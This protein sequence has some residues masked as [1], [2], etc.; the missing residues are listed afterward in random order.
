MHFK[1]FFTVLV[2]LFSIS[3]KCQQIKKG[4]LIK[5]IPLTNRTSIGFKKFSKKQ[6]L[7]YNPVIIK[8]GNY[9]RVKGFDEENGSD[10]FIKI[11][12]DKN[13]LVL[14]Y[15]IKGYVEDGNNKVLHENALCV[16]V[17]IEKYKVVETLQSACGGEW[18]EHNQWMYDDKIIFSPN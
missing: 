8:N 2:S 16:I 13:Y 15:I 4:K 6:G 9:Y 12:P 1:I 5:I 18:N 3:V 11:S 7:F 14:A 10:I 17:N